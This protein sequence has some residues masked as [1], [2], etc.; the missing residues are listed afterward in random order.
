VNE[1]GG[2]GGIHGSPWASRN[3][4]E[5]AEMIGAQDAPHQIERRHEGLRQEQSDHGAVQLR[6]PAVSRC[7]QFENEA[8]APLGND[9]R[10]A[11]GRSRRK[12]SESTDKPWTG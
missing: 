6:G 4:D 12:S 11:H 5:F 9:A 7:C 8:L 10:A 2:I 1:G 3:W